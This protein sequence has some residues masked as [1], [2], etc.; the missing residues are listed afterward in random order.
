MYFCN[1]LNNPVFCIIILVWI[2]YSSFY[3]GPQTLYVE[4]DY[5][6]GCRNAP[7]Y[8][9]SLFIAWE[10]VWYVMT[11][12]I[13]IALAIGFNATSVVR[14]HRQRRLFNNINEDKSR[15]KNGHSTSSDATQRTRRAA[16]GLQR[17]S[18]ALITLFT[19]TSFPTQVIALIQDALGNR[20]SSV[21]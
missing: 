13:P 17:A 3:N 11:Y 12:P 15:P 21:S 2:V 1:L 9:S 8:K 20:K 14:L 7:I 6:T 5:T 19:I 4:Y 10:Y 16:V 18:I